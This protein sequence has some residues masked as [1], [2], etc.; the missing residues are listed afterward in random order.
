MDIALEA[1]L[2]PNSVRNG[3]LLDGCIAT[4]A[5]GQK[6]S[7]TPDFGQSL[8]VEVEANVEVTGAAPHFRT[9]SGGL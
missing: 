9:A 5:V 3:L 4:T 7:H 6:Q 2:M 8:T 1:F